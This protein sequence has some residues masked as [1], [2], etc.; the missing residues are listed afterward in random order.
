MR[1]DAKTDTLGGIVDGKQ[2]PSFDNRDGTTS[3]LRPGARD[4]FDFPDTFARIRHLARQIDGEELAD[5]LS[6]L[7]RELP[8][9][10]RAAI[11]WIDLIH[12]LVQD[13][14]PR[15]RPKG[16]GPLKKEE[17]KTVIVYLVRAD[18]YDIPWV[19]RYLEPLVVD[20]L[21]DLA[22]DA[23]VEFLNTN[24][25]RDPNWPRGSSRL[26]MS[27]VWRRFKRGVRRVFGWLFRPFGLLASRLYFAFHRPSVLRPA[28]RSAIDAVNRESQ[29]VHR[30]GLLERLAKVGEW[31]GHNRE[32]LV[33]GFKL[34]TIV[35]DSV[36]A[37]TWL[38]GPE[39]K[40]QAR[41]FVYAALDEF[42]F[43]YSNRIVKVKLDR[44]IGV[45]IDSAVH[46]FNR[47][48][49]FEHSSDP[50]ATPGATPPRSYGPP[51]D[52][53][54]ARPG[55]R[56]SRDPLAAPVSTL[57]PGRRRPAARRYRY[58]GP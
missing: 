28:I 36:E 26:T 23:V 41:R 13:A 58:R 8:H 27:E 30:Q 14:E 4:P 51:D 37:L 40:V 49:L 38:D 55:R 18:R 3:A 39:K 57:P 2:R 25:P 53:D 54:G 10:E 31:I 19:P 6:V 9:F 33:E 45:A 5:W 20:V 24:A 35:V 50:A 34:V 43:D 48:G 32:T 7:D 15:Y 12:V 16:R 42:G 44:A 21:A 47:R 11:A 29:T 46:L 17:V 56:R 1:L 22:I 52:K